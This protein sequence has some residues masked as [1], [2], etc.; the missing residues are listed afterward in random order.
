MGLWDLTAQSLRCPLLLMG[1][2]GRW[3]LTGLLVPRGHSDQLFRLGQTA[4]SA[5]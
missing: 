4:L 2:K 1:R 3:D 5:H